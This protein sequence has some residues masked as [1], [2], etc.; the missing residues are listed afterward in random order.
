MGWVWVVGRRMGVE[1]H[2]GIGVMD[3]R[4]TEFGFFL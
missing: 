1:K 4:R 3:R 2:T